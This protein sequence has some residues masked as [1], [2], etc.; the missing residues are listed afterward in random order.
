MKTWFSGTPKE[1]VAYLKELD[2]NP[3]HVNG[4]T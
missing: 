1:L 2:I 4:N 3:E